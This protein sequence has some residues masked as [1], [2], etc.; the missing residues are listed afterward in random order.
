MRGGARQLVESFLF[1]RL[2]P[3]LPS[4]SLFPL[5][6]PPAPVSMPCPLLRHG[7]SFLSIWFLR[8]GFLQMVERG[9]HTSFL[10]SSSLK[11][12]TESKTVFF[13]I[14]SFVSFPS[15]IYL[16]VFSFT[17]ARGAFSPFH[18]TPFQ[19]P[20]QI[21]N[22]FPPT[23]PSPTAHLRRSGNLNIYFLF[24]PYLRL[25]NGFLSYFY[26]FSCD[27]FSPH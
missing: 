18:P 26:L 5:L 9:G 1:I 16:F 10:F 22:I 14:Y 4:L 20:E 15:L 8:V 2:Y 17:Q 24:T 21:K 6:L 19:R 25:E 3:L 13:S 27:R 23:I 7:F 12:K 11:V